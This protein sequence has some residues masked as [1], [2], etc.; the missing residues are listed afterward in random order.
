MTLSDEL[1]SREQLADELE[2]LRE[3]LS[4]LEGARTHRDSRVDAP[5]APSFAH[6][7]PSPVLRFD[8]DGIV[9][10][11][12]P[13]GE[14]TFGLEAMVGASL[15]SILPT[16]SALDVRQIIF[17]DEHYDLAAEIRGALVPFRRCGHQR[18]R[19]GAHLR[20]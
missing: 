11:I 18:V 19:G 7:N 2:D 17:G 15:A 3:R 5:E 14:E 20:L 12:N 9:R 1:K 16:S 4:N 6:F 13:A 10:T 8:S